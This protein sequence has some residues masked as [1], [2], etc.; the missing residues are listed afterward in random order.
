MLAGLQDI[1][2]IGGS[3]T[4]PIPGSYGSGG[5]TC[6]FLKELVNESQMGFADTLVRLTLRKG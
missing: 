3:A 4:G 6:R 5:V 1:E 2:A